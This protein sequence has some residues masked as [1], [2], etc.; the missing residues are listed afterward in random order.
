MLQHLTYSTSIFLCRCLQN[1]ALHDLFSLAYDFITIPV[2]REIHVR[3]TSSLV[4][5]ALICY[6]KKEETYNFQTK[7]EPFLGQK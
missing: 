4:N 1:L 5:H 2:F 7:I 6:P 3:V